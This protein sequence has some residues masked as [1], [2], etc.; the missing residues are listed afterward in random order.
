MFKLDKAAAYAALGI[1]L[2]PSLLH[3]KD[4]SSTRETTEIT[5]PET[6]RTADR[7]SASAPVLFAA[8][9]L[10]NDSGY[11]I[12][13]DKQAAEEEAAKRTRDIPPSGGKPVAAQTDPH[14]S[15]EPVT[16]VGIAA[17][18]LLPVNSKMT[19]RTGNTGSLVYREG[20]TFSGWYVG[21]DFGNSFRLDGE[22]NFARASLKE[23]KTAG[24][25][26]KPK[27]NLWSIG[28]FVNGYYDFYD[29]LTANR[30]TPYVIAGLG[31]KN[32]NL[33]GADVNGTKIWNKGH[34][35]AFAYQLGCGSGVQITKRIMLDVSYRYSDTGNMH[36]DAIKTR[37]PNHTVLLGVRYLFR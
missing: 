21:R 27:S 15:R 35:T 22:L 9:L 33:S 16:Y 32:A 11:T 13:K 8:V 12:I 1:L 24:A 29:L 30:I 34:D 31:F 23:I 37:F 25:T 5:A 26:S 18:L 6:G 20:L 3:A 2:L 7:K 17:G 28:L 4:L 10:K 14:I 36:I 19:D